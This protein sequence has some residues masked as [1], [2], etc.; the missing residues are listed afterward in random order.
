MIIL[1]DRLIISKMY[2]QF[3]WTL[4]NSCSPTKQEGNDVTVECRS[5][6]VLTVLKF[7]LEVGTRSKAEE[8][9]LTFLN[10]AEKIIMHDDLGLI[11]ERILEE[12]GVHDE[13]KQ[14]EMESDSSGKVS[15]QGM[16]NGNEC[17]YS[18][19]LQDQ[20]HPW[21]REMLVFCPHSVYMHSFYRLIFKCVDKVIKDGYS[22]R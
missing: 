4:L 6:L 11:A 12:L 21:I 18:K 13:S 2:F 10:V 15:V 14:M 9:V 17:D 3:I 22:L 20:C 5:E 1:R 8:S 7:T 16:D 19:A